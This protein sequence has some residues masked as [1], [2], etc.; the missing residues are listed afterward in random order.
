MKRPH[1][2]GTQISP[3]RTAAW[4]EAF[5]FYRHP[6]DGAAILR[7][8]NRFSRAD[9]DLAARVLDCVQV[10]SEQETLRGYRNALQQ[11]EGWSRD[12]ALRNGRWFFVGFGRAGESGQAMVRCFR[13]ANQLT[14]AA[15]DELFCS[16]TE[17]PSKRIT[18]KDHIV[19]IDDFSG[20]GRQVCTMWPVLQE[21]IASDATCHLVL[22]SATRTAMSRIVTLVNMAL[23]VHIV[24][25]EDDNLFNPRCKH[26][27]NE[28]KALVERYGKRADK[29]SPRGFGDCGLLFVLSHKTPNNTIPILHAY[30]NGW[31]RLFPRYVPLANEH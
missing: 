9:R 2:R 29:K 30:H 5:R 21:L 15:Y 12:S 8:L 20:S 16:A 14:S 1:P 3:Q 19:F 7:W 18:A 17:L 4:L 23:T 25:E 27:S 31:K 11:L 24:L 22:T 6:R 28:E 13:E 10:V 26:F